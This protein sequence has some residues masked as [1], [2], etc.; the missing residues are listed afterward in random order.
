MPSFILLPDDEIDALVEYV[1]YLSLR[2][3]TEEKL[4]RASY[5]LS[6]GEKLP[7]DR[8]FL[9]EQVLAEVVEP[10]QAA[11]ESIIA[12][13]ERAEPDAQA[14]AAG[15]ELFFGNK[16]GCVKCH[17]VTALGD[18]QT[19]EFDD[20][21]KAVFEFTKT[22][23]NTRE[24]LLEDAADAKSAEAS[25]EEEVAEADEPQVDELA[26]VQHQLAVL[27]ADTLPPRNAIPRNL[28]LGNYRGGRR[29]LDLFR[30][31]HAGI[32]GTPM[33]G[34]GPSAPGAQGVLSPEEIWQLVD[35]I[36]SLPFEPISE[37]PPSGPT[38]AGRDRL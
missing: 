28:R 20:W 29:P 12:P 3:E 15:R 21:S 32:T 25:G 7:T 35:Y 11:D 4:L 31:I 19:N 33:P 2:G 13:P 5:D 26:S 6:E 34:V 23:N 10:W 17:G 38:T 27:K 1:K 9:V 22:L 16:A 18:G 37:P 30:R 14:I 8:E 24:S 36:R